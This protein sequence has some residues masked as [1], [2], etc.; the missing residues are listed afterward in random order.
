MPETVTL[1]HTD[2]GNLYCRECGHAILAE[3]LPPPPTPDAV[4]AFLTALGERQRAEAVAEARVG[5]VK[6]AAASLADWK[7]AKAP[8]PEFPGWHIVAAA[9]KDWKAARDREAAAWRAL[10]AEW[11]Q[12]LDK[13]RPG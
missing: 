12:V 1:R 11:Q 13:L 3:W 9:V 6:A 7:G 2:H 4:A 5:E 8:A 10:P